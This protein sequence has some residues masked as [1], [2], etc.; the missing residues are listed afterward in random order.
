MCDEAVDDSL[1]ALELIPE[2]FVTSKMIKKLRWRTLYADEDS[3][4]VTF[5]VMK[6]VFFG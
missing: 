2:W 6:R 3:G 1:A 4:D 5:V